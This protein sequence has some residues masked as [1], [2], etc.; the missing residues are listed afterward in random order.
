M[1]TAKEPMQP[2]REWQE[3]YRKHKIVAE[4]D[5]PMQTKNSRENMHDTTNAVASLL[6]EVEQLSF[7]KATQYFADTIAEFTSDL[8]SDQLFN[9]LLKAATDNYNYTKREYDKATRFLELLGGTQ[10]KG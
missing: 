5:E 4:I 1:D 2:I 9:A 6:N 10:E 7:D 8:S 3:W